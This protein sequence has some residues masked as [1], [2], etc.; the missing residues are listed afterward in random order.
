M[1]GLQ[2]SVLILNYL[3]D[4]KK[5]ANNINQLQFDSAGKITEV[6]LVTKN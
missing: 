2:P 5:N 4:Q 3:K 1:I 6:E